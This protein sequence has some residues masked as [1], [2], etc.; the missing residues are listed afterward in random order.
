MALDDRSLIYCPACNAKYDVSGVTSGKRFVCKACRVTIQ[1]PDGSGQPPFFKLS[2]SR[3]LLK[4]EL[5]ID[6]A[7]PPGSGS[8]SFTKMVATENDYVLVDCFRETV[9][10]PETLAIH[11]HGAGDDANARRY[12]RLAAS[13]A[14][15]TLAFDRAAR[16]YQFAL[17]LETEEKVRLELLL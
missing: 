5:I 7:P 16:L 17:D 8:F 14:M 4:P 2:E 6:D 11:F 9:A 1:I 10:D 12:A 13:E 15:E 3:E